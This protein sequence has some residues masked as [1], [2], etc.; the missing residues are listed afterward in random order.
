MKS[1]WIRF[2]TS[3]G[4]GTETGVIVP[5]AY[6]SP[7]KVTFASVTDGTS[8]T[9]AIAE[10]FVRPAQYDLPTQNDWGDDI[11]YLNGWDVTNTRSTIGIPSYF[12]NP[13][14][15]HNIDESQYQSHAWA[16]GVGS[17]HPSGFNAV[18][19]DGS[20]HNVTYGIDPGVFN[21]LGGRADGLVAPADDY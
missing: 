20:V 13:S 14:Q 1:P 21:A 10:K 19:A 16:M 12:P 8:S 17:A 5:G 6:D 3:T 4:L 2:P 11:Q 15:D 18:F 7:G 9:I